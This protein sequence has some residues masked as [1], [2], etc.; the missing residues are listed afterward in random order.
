M[1]TA[2]VNNY[3][4]KLTD[5]KEDKDLEQASYEGILYDLRRKERELLVAYREGESAA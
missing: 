3:L 1:P 5:N 2:V 4:T